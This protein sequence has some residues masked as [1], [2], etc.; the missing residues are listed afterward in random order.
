MVKKRSKFVLNRVHRR[1]ERRR[2]PFLIKKIQARKIYAR[3]YRR[4]KSSFYHRRHRSR[5]LN[6]YWLVHDRKLGLHWPKL[7]PWTKR[8]KD[9]NLHIVRRLPA[10]FSRINIFVDFFRM[11]SAINL[12]KGLITKARIIIRSIQSLVNRY[13]KYNK[14]FLTRQFR[15]R[16]ILNS[17]SVFSIPGLKSQTKG[18]ILDK[19]PGLISTVLAHLEYRRNSMRFSPLSYYLKRL[20]KFDLLFDSSLSTWSVGLPQTSIFGI[21][22]SHNEL[23]L[24]RNDLLVE[25]EEDD[26]FNFWDKLTTFKW[27]FEYKR[28][29]KSYQL[30]LWFRRLRSYRKLKKER[31]YMG[32]FRLFFYYL[33]NINEASLTNMWK[34]FRQLDSRYNLTIGGGNRFLQVLQLRLSNLLVF[35]GLATN[36]FNA[37]EA[38]KIGLVRINGFTKIN[39]YSTLMIGDMLQINLDAAQGY[40]SLFSDLYWVRVESQTNFVGFIQ[41]MFSMLLFT[42][43][44]WPRQYELLETDSRL[45]NRMLLQLLRLFPFRAGK[46]TAI[47]KLP[48]KYSLHQNITK[49]FRHKYRQSRHKDNIIDVSTP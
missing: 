39:P 2:N 41:V 16:A 29:R 26:W 32:L 47:E 4:I 22:F 37:L 15:L 23:R 49:I 42:V 21:S 45:N 10:L 6:R 25:A 11:R 14:N 12:T 33:G 8:A 1:F 30:A 27:F 19:E 46:Q 3:W 18:I 34:R 48:R 17:M 38:S 7:L 28:W 36:S 35:L 5:G 9:E 20:I 44:R 40:L 43:I 31:F 24:L 13:I